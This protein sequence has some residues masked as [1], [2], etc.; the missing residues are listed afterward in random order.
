MPVRLNS[1]GGGSVTLDVPATAGTFTV[2]LPAAN[3]DLVITGGGSTVQ[4]GAGSVSAP[5]ITFTGDTNT[6]I[7]SPAAD[8]IAFTEG[9][10]ES[11]RLNSAGNAIFAGTVSMAGSFLRNRLI[12]GAMLID[13][14]T[15]GGS[16]TVN[17]ATRTY[18]LDRW[19]GYGQGSDGVFTVQ[20]SSDAPAGFQ[21]SALITVTTADSSI[22]SN[23]L[24]TF[25]QSIE[26]FNVSDLAW[27]T[28]SAQTVTLSFWVKSSLTGTFGGVLN[29]NGDSRSYPFT[30]SISAAN[31]WEQK[32]VVI[33]GDT[34]GT[35][36]ANTNGIGV[37]VSFSL[38]AGSGFVSAAGSWVGA[39]RYGATGQT[40]IISTLNAT[41]LVTGVQFEVGSAA[42]P[43]ERRLVGQ[44][45]AFCQRYYTRSDFTEYHVVPAPN[46][47]YLGVYRINFPVQMRAN[48]S[49]GVS[50]SATNAV[51]DFGWYTQN[52]NYMVHYITASVSTNAFMFF[53]WT[54]TA[55]L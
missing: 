9:G 42:T 44:E 8:T 39:A 30:F 33:S 7:Y 32:S 19:F 29:N 26:A 35:W 51:Q 55:E 14:R 48:P 54:A 50:Y 4:F 27:G 28:A 52:Y 5:S 46:A 3:G 17:S 11:L 21:N 36:L 41:F 18:T 13:Q 49:V 53:V 22:A 38:G 37:T 24:Y 23:Q 34:A 16:F 6:G 1:S 43:F 10:A 20:R 40:Q 12:N 25:G 45:I 2:N 31:T 15:G 47:T